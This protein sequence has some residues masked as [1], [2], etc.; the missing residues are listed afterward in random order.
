MSLDVQKL[1]NG[2]C[3]VM[4]VGKTHFLLPCWKKDQL[5]AKYANYNSAFV[6]NAI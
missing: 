5:K 1:K 2:P 6:L 3:H 4:R